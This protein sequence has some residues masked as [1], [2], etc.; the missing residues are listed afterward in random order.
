MIYKFSEAF[1]NALE[2]AEK[3]AIEYGHNLIGTEHILYGITVEEKSLAC[4]VL[5]KQN[6]VPSLI[7]NKIKEILGEKKQ[8]ISKTDGFTPKAKKII[9]S[10]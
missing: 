1:K 10:L 9:E 3:I 5:N 4:K 7:A 2:S 6:I 8:K